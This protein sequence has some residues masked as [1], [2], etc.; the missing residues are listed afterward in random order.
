MTISLFLQLLDFLFL[1]VRSVS[2]VQPVINLNDIFQDR[3]LVTLQEI[4]NSES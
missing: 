4:L 2:S 3:L 1:L